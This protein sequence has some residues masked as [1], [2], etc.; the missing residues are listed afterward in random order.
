MVSKAATIALSSA[1]LAGTGCAM[2]PFAAIS[3]G[4]LREVVCVARDDRYCVLGGEAA[5]ERGAE[6]GADT[7][8]D[9]NR[10]LRTGWHLEPLLRTDGG[11]NS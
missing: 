5:N 1:V 4:D 11:Q 10:F 9:G 3:T 6:S 2:P 8:Y 7:D